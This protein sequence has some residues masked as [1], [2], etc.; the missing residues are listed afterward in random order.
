MTGGTTSRGLLREI[1]DLFA[2]GVVGE[3]GDGELLERFLDGRSPAAEAAFR[4]LVE[5]HGPMVLRV[6]RQ[7]LTDR[8]AAEDAFQA[9]FLVLA[10]RASSIRKRGSVAFWL[11]GVARR[12]ALRMRVE[13]ARRHR[14]EGR[15]GAR[16]AD[17]ADL[18]DGPA[19]SLE[20]WTELHAE[21]DRLPRKYRLP[22]IHCYFNGLTHEQAA[23]L[24]RWPVGTVKTRLTR[25]REQLRRR[26]QRRG[27]SALPVALP[28]G[29]I[30]FDAV[31]ISDELL[32]MT[33]RNGVSARSGMAAG[34]ASPTVLKVTKGVLKA[35]WF[36]TFKLAA[37]ALLAVLG[38]GLGAAVLAQRPARDGHAGDAPKAV[39]PN[40]GDPGEMELQLAGT[41]ELNPDRI[42]QVRPRL[43]SRVDRVF[44]DLGA[45]VK[46][47]DPLLEVLS[48]E[49]A[50]LKNGYESALAQLDHDKRSLQRME[51]MAESRVVPSKVLLD[52]QDAVARSALQLKFARDKLLLLGLNE[53]EIGQIPR[54]SGPGRA[55]MII[56]SPMDGLVTQ[57]SAVVGN[58]YAAN[59]MLLTIAQDDPLWVTA[60]V[61]E[62]QIDKLAIG[63]P[64]TV[65]FPFGNQSV[66]AR[67]ESVG[68]V[69][70]PRTQT[71]RIRASVPN[72]DHRIKPGMFVRVTV[73]IPPRTA[74]T[75]PNARPSQSPSPPQDHASPDLAERLSALERRVDEL[76]KRTERGADGR[77]LQRLDA[78]ERQVGDLLGKQQGR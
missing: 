60:N 63:D 68:T 11:F 40:A 59:D 24:L 38:M 46:A 27:W 30:P 9:T 37:V 31:K 4:A 43:E 14:L 75:A 2:A 56:P 1:E 35:M 28:G 8:H 22:I 3:L 54:L 58:D 18:A 44:V 29:R 16:L 17:L 23:T 57:R 21:I 51:P 67:L 42:L 13:E 49:L 36:H 12:A 45:R 34:S 41:T 65:H 77:L 64:V 25:A 15:C 74:V 70:D 5:R 73:G 19:D 53:E 69:F 50:T 78:L 52:A 32:S 7:T 48:M 26:L 55:R 6:C 72:A 39:S 47:G 10:Q 62:Q 61:S 71:A 33:S 20:S 76:A 66:Q